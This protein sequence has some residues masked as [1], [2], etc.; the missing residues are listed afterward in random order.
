MNGNKWS[1]KS[2]LNDSKEKEGERTEADTGVKG[3]EVV[4]PAAGS[5]DRR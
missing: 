1:N 5:G 3:N 4:E 2:D